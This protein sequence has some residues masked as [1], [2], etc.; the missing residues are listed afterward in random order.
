MRRSPVESS[1]PVGIR[2]AYI[3]NSTPPPA[4]SRRTR[5]S[6]RGASA[7]AL[8]RMICAASMRTSRA[9]FD[10]RRSRASRRASWRRTF[11]APSSPQKSS[12]QGMRWFASSAS[13]ASI[14]TS[15][16]ARSAVARPSSAW[17]D[18]ATFA[19]NARRSRARK[20]RSFATLGA[21]TPPDALRPMWRSAAALCVRSAIATARRRRHRSAFAQRFDAL[22]VFSRMSVTRSRSA[23]SGEQR[24]TLCDI[25]SVT[26]GRTAGLR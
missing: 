1:R 11:A 24:P 23:H 2:S 9:C 26:C 18:S 7:R 15:G 10:P 12:I 4:R 5:R 8:R 16:T 6:S 3:A 21:R 19:A 14:R 25:Q 20:T 13:R 17:P 22:S